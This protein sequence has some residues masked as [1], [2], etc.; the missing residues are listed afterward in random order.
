MKFNSTT[1]NSIVFQDWQVRIIA[2][3]LQEYRLRVGRTK[4]GRSMRQIAEDICL[5]EGIGEFF[6]DFVN[7]TDDENSESVWPITRRVLD[8]WLTGDKVGESRR[9]SRPPDIKLV[10]I[11]AFLCAKNFLSLE[12]L[13]DNNSTHESPRVLS[14]YLGVPDSVVE[15]CASELQPSYSHLT[16]SGE[17]ID[18]FQKHTIEFNIANNGKLILATYILEV[19]QSNVLEL[20]ASGADLKGKGLD[21]F[22]YLD[23]PVV[24]KAYNGWGVFVSN[25]FLL[26][27]LKS[28]DILAEENLTIQIQLE[29][30]GENKAISTMGVL[31]SPPHQRI[32]GKEMSSYGDERKRY[33]R[34]VDS[35]DLFKYRETT[36]QPEIYH[37]DRHTDKYLKTP[38]DTG[39]MHPVSAIVSQLLIDAARSGD[40]HEV[41]RALESGADVNFR[42][43][44]TSATALHCAAA[45][46]SD[47][48]I[49][50]LLEH[51][52]IDALVLDNRQLLPSDYVDA[53]RAPNLHRKLSEFQQRQAEE[54]GVSYRSF[55]VGEPD[56]TPPSSKPN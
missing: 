15:A 55:L 46:N 51:P 34:F 53:R 45:I 38:K 50:L 22:F 32:S 41:E 43:Q 12:T 40:E 8:A 13:E 39:I 11:A 23:A 18:Q 5:W 10:A 35:N 37:K 31:I 26:C 52:D 16:S 21:Y 28:D 3:R 25:N 44:S 56:K 47:A 4:R 49:S 42:D 24:I 20:M 54:R 27:I 33:C 48:I 9:Y 17:K 19:R 7:S 2:S 29:P 6:P 1:A 30:S 14:N 36:R